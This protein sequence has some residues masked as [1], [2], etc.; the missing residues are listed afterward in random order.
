MVNI[1]K[2]CDII[3]VVHHCWPLFVP[4][5]AYYKGCSISSFGKVVIFHDKSFLINF[6]CN[7]VCLPQ[8]CSSIFIVDEFVFFYFIILLI[9]VYLP[10][11][12]ENIITFLEKLCQLGECMVDWQCFCFLN[13]HLISMSPNKKYKLKIS[14]WDSILNSQLDHKNICV[15]IFW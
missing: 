9:H 4:D 14:K 10:L 8:Y 12:F 15:N 6:F 7:V 3:E 1:V 5:N 2:S 11:F 13:T